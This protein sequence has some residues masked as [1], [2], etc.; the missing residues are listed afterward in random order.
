MLDRAHDVAV[1]DE[2]EGARRAADR[3]QSRPLEQR[4]DLVA[5][6]FAEDG[7]DPE[8]HLLECRVCPPVLGQHFLD[9]ALVVRVGEFLVAAH[10]VVL[11]EPGRVVGVVAVGRTARGDDDASRRR[12]R[13]RPRA[14]C[15]C[16]ARP[17]RTRV[18]GSTSGPGVTIAARWTTVSMACRSSTSASPGSAHVVHDVLDARQAA[19]GRDLADVARDDAGRIAARSRA[20]RERL[21]ETCA[22][23]AGGAGD[24]DA[25]AHAVALGAAA[26][27]RRRHQLAS[28]RPARMCQM[29]HQAA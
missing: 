1:V 25:V 7:P 22:E 3:E 28:D 2:D 6:G 9:E 5:R 15:G 24:E 29:P 11:G 13:R 12:P 18:R 10:R 27:G 19:I 16:R 26:G 23:I 17:P 14:R 8:H 4:R 21:D 20:G